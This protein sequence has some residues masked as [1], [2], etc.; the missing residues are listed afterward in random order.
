MTSTHEVFNQA[1]S[2]VDYNLFA[3]NQAL[4]TALKFN[5]PGLNIAPLH[6]LGASLGTREMQTHARLANVNTPQLRTHD[7]T[8]RRVDEVEC[9]PI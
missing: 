6:A 3:G 2:L 1:D 4:Q 5:A 8:G 7:R 9:R